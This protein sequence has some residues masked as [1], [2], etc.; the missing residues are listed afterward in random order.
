M[1]T[2]C[3]VKQSTKSHILNYCKKLQNYFII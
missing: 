2:A 3:K 1:H